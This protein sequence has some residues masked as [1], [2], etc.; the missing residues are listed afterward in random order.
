[1]TPSMLYLWLA[2]VFT[3]G[4]LFILTGIRNGRSWYSLALVVT[5][6]IM[7]AYVP[8]RLIMVT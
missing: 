1:M 2:F 6:L 3:G 7:L 4:A 5:G 8:T